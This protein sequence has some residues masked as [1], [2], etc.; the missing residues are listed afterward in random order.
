LLKKS[1]QLK[2][3]EVFRRIDFFNSNYQTVVN[4]YAG[5]FSTPTASL[6]DQRLFLHQPQTPD[7][8]RCRQGY[9]DS[10]RWA[11]ADSF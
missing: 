6:I 5:G 10:C 8:V 2:N 11:C 7:V 3:K 4:L 9:A 1:K